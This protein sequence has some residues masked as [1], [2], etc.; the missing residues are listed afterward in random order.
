MKKDRATKHKQMDSL[1]PRKSHFSGCAKKYF[2][3]RCAKENIFRKRQKFGY[4]I[5][6][7]CSAS[8][9][10]S[11]ADKCGKRRTQHLKLGEFGWPK[12]V[13]IRFA[14]LQIKLS[15][16]SAISWMIAEAEII[17]S[18]IV[19]VWFWAI[20]ILRY[21]DRKKTPILIYFKL[22]LNLC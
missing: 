9:K 20:T 4:A 22:Q 17:T 21:I 8:L 5:R 16:T 12:F 1:A 3:W 11:Q 18:L 2:S 15:Q 19:F 13:A 10:R 7:C 6:V 14:I